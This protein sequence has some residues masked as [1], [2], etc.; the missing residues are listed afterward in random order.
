MT[1][2]VATVDIILEVQPYHIFVNSIKSSAGREN[3]IFGLKK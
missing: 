1:T 2:A 3:Y